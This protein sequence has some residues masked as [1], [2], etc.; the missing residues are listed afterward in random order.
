MR[1][2]KGRDN[3]A[4]GKILVRLKRAEEGNFG[5]HRSEG[6]GVIAL[7]IGGYGPGYR[8]YFGVDGDEIILLWGGTKHSQQD[9]IKK[10]RAFWEDYNA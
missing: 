4:I 5:D 8:V 7:K 9:D 6:G 2:V 10:A 1:T 3:V